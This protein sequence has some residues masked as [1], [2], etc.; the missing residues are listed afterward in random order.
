[1]KSD[2]EGFVCPF[3]SKAVCGIILPEQ[4]VEPFATR[5]AFKLKEAYPDASLDL[6]EKCTGIKFVANEDIT[7]RDQALKFLQDNEDSGDPL[8]WLAD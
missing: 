2:L 5:C 3:E 8:N 6:I 4:L 7:S 1:L